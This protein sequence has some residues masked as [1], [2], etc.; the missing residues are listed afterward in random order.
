[1]LRITF[2]RGG[3]SPAP[4]IPALS[5]GI[6]SDLYYNGFLNLIALLY[7]KRLGRLCNLY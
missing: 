1:M 6:H 7:F 2:T 3:Y 4:E 5:P